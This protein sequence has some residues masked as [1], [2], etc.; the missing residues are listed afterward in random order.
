MHYFSDLNKYK[1]FGRIGSG[2]Y[3]RVHWCSYANET[4]D[5][6][7][8]F[9]RSIEAFRIRREVHILH[10]LQVCPNIVKLLGVVSAPKEV[11]SET[12]KL[13]KDARF[14]E[15]V[16]SNSEKQRIYKL[17]EDTS[18][19][20]GSENDF[21]FSTSY[22][23]SD[24]DFAPSD[25]GTHKRIRQRL[26]PK[27]HRLG[28][29]FE[30]VV[31]EYFRSMF[32]KFTLQDIIYYSRELLQA[33]SCVHAQGIFHRDIKPENILIDPKRR[34][35]K[36]ADWGLAEYLLPDQDYS[37]RVATRYYK[38]PEL[39]IDYKFY[40]SPLDMWSFGCVFAEM[41]FLRQ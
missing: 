15:G 32:A 31:G 18:T 37:V 27:G 6:A 4:R 5:C 14:K 17:M 19:T 2:K 3:S 33:I 29:V 12:L 10:H 40:G 39:L 26:P 13:A 28:L 36:L 21:A 7:V 23:S 11:L 1:I 34:V 22:S 9:L 8:K 41:V 30:G 16:R 35:I 24:G 20:S 38:S 25:E